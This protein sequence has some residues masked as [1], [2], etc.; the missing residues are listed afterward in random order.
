MARPP[1][2]IKFG[3]KEI[4]KAT[5]LSE[6]AIRDHRNRGTF[7]DDDLLSVAQFVVKSQ[8]KKLGRKPAEFA[9]TYKDLQKATGLSASAVYQHKERGSFREDDFQSLVMFVA[10]FGPSKFKRDLFQAMVQSETL[11]SEG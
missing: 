8:G 2:E 7:Q 9:V 10:R 1:Y 11:A 4:C 6:S 5:G 3:Y